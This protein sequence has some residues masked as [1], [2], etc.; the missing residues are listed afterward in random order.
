MIGVGL[1]GRGSIEARGSP[2]QARPRSADARRSLDAAA[3]A[4]DQ[5]EEQDFA[6]RNGE[7]GPAQRPHMSR[8]VHLAKGGRQ[9]GREAVAAYGTPTSQVLPDSGRRERD[10]TRIDGWV[11]QQPELDVSRAGFQLNRR[12]GEVEG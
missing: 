6:T 10:L 1:D 9:V 8:S 2:L 7:D 4:R 5:G 3:R 11:L 12:P